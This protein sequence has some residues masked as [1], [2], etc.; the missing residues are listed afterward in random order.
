[1]EDSATNPL[2]VIFFLPRI[3]RWIRTALLP[4]INLSQTP[5]SV[6]A[7]CLGT[8]GCAP[9][10]GAFYQLDSPLRHTSL[11]TSPTCFFSSRTTPS[12]D[13]SDDDNMVFTFPP[14]WDRLCHS[15]IGSSSLSFHGLSR[16]EPIYFTPDR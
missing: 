5:H 11:I 8:C 13:T 15:C 6:S 12:F 16:G 10:S 9:A 4:L 2:R 7:E 1:V 14:T 3:C